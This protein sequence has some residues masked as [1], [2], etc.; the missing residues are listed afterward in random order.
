[1]LYFS[2]N[3]L[4]LRAL[5]I[6]PFLMAIN[7]FSGSFAISSYAES[8]FRRSGSPV[9]PQMSSIVMAAIQVVSTYGASQLMDR[10]GRKMLLLVSLSSSFLAL[11]IAG[12]YSYL[13]KHDYDVMDFNWIPVVSISLHIAFGSIGILPVPYVML[14]E[15]IPQRVRYFCGNLLYK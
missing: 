11:V 14:S 7:Q 6:C 5:M 2:V 3:P 4:A 13:A 15:V 12:T 9:D 10:V 1:M 8:F